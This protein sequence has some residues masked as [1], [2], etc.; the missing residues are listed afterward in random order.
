MVTFFGGSSTPRFR[1]A[2]PDP[3][4][5]LPHLRG[6]VSHKG[7]AGKASAHIRL[8]RH[9]GPPHALE[10]NTIHFSKQ[11]LSSLL[12]EIR[13]SFAACSI[14]LSSGLHGNSLIAFEMN[15]EFI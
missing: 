11:V 6:Q 8:H 14:F 7:P 4:L 1:M 3:V 2:R 15:K 13:R 10:I 9:L 12:S 5:G